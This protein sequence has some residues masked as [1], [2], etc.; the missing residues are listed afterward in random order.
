MVQAM[1]VTLHLYSESSTDDERRPAKPR[2]TAQ[3]QNAMPK[4]MYGPVYVHNVK[5]STTLPIMSR[6]CNFA[7]RKDI[8]C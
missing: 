4:G 3:C 5:A 2:K 6:N 1:R 7:A 8:H